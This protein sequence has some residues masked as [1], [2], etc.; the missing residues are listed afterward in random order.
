MPLAIALL[1]LGFGRFD[2]PPNRGQSAA[3]DPPGPSY[4]RSFA[5]CIGVNDYVNLP[6]S[7]QLKYANADAS[8]L[9]KVLT[10]SY[11]F[12]KDRVWTLLGPQATREA[13]AKRLESLY[14]SSLVG[15]SDRI[16]IF[17]AGHGIQAK[18]ENGRQI[19]FLVPS[20]AKL[21]WP[22]E[23][24]P[25]V[26]ARECIDMSAWFENLAKFGKAKHVL[27]IADA[28]FSGNFIQSPGAFQMADLRLPVQAENGSTS[29]SS[30]AQIDAF[31][32]NKS[33]EVL[34]SGIKDQ[35]AQERPELQHGLF[36]SKLL[37]FLGKHAKDPSFAFS[38]ETLG[39]EVSAAVSNENGATQVPLHDAFGSQGRF[40][41]DPGGTLRPYREDEQRS[42][43][44]CL[45][46]LRNYMVGL[47]KTTLT[48][49]EGGQT[50]QFNRVISAE[51]DGTTMVMTHEIRYDEGT[52]N[53]KPKWATIR[54]IRTVP[55]LALADFSPSQVEIASVRVSNHPWVRYWQVT[56]KIQRNMPWVQFEGKY[57]NSDGAT[58][59]HLV[60]L[61]VLHVPFYSEQAAKVFVDKMCNMQRVAKRAIGNDSLHAN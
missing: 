38:A 2:Q 34:T 9:A 48:G 26:L 5:L 25:D 39:L 8:E 61:D 32:R 44:N 3:P 22:D 7:A 16:L 29:G 43:K 42:L 55:M 19:A 27:L 40:L 49:I 20:G 23:T 12:S 4:E 35:V 17:F 37:Y 13:I 33:R 18:L 28:C 46:E 30:K 41:F 53:G 15:P 10:Q 31:L 45:E 54:E 36:T 14:D 1:C 56:W 57:L 21:S 60:N 59:G 50:I 52:E 6:A 24:R 11:G 58:N 51:L 47:G